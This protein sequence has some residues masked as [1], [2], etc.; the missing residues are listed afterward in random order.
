MKYNYGLYRLRDVRGAF[1]GHFV[2]K[3]S[4]K[5][6]LGVKWTCCSKYIKVSYILPKSLKGVQK[7][8]KK[9]KK[10]F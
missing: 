5:H 1:Q 3:A 10:N 9:L 6:F 7:T 2:E 4:K 8:E